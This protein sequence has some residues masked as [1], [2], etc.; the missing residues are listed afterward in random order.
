MMIG[1]AKPYLIVGLGNPGREHRHNRHNIGFM[2]LDQLAGRLDG[3]FSRMKMNALMTA[4]RHKGHRIILIKPQSF[5]NLSGKA[6][7][8]F[9]RFYKLP[10]ENL[11]VVYDDVDLPFQTLRMKPDGGDAGQ[12]GVRSIIQELGT[13]EFPRLRLGINRPPG[14][15]SVS[16]YVLLDFSDQ[17]GETLPFVLDQAADAILAFIEM[18]LNQAMTIYNQSPPE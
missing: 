4:V 5:M 18:G 17:E 12:K 15:M 7:A 14:R 9:V 3:S 10:L 13:K 16:S 8:S 2:V 11:L 6:V 1:R